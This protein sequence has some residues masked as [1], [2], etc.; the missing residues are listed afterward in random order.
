MEIHPFFKG[1]SFDV[2]Y[3]EHVFIELSR[4]SVSSN[5]FF[6]GAFIEKLDG[7]EVSEDNDTLYISL[8]NG[9]KNLL[10]RGINKSMLE[11]LR[12]FCTKKVRNC[13]RTK[14]EC[15]SVR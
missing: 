6:S 11:L 13:F 9:G 7:S 2:C 12:I 4:K 5:G 3:I 15:L 8:Q 10:I 1:V 14:Y